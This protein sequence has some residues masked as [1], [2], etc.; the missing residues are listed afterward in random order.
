M[1]IEKLVCALYACWLSKLWGE[2]E[3]ALVAGVHESTLS[4]FAKAKY[5]C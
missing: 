3:I 4:I 1:S 2:V 5:F